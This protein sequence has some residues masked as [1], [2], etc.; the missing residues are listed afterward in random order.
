MLLLLLAHL[1]VLTS[2]RFNDFIE[3]IFSC[4]SMPFKERSQVK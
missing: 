2:H 3:R 4:E 1:G